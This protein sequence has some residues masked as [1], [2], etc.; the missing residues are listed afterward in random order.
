M[1]AT[2]SASVA[3]AKLLDAWENVPYTAKKRALIAAATEAGFYVD[4]WMRRNYRSSSG[5]LVTVHG[6]TV[7][8]VEFYVVGDSSRDNV[9][10]QLRQVV[11]DHREKEAAQL[12]PEYHRERILA[13]VSEVLADYHCDA[14]N[15]PPEVQEIVQR[16]LY[17]EA[18]RI[19]VELRLEEEVTI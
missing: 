11:T 8:H 1:M 19:G 6:E 17:E 9:V 13:A 14:W 7:P 5:Y 18:E 15:H 4:F 2:E 10:E 12:K 16:V 3:L